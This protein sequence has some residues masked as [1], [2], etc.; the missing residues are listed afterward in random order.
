MLQGL[1][2]EAAIQ[3]TEGVVAAVPVL[4]DELVK[5]IY[6]SDSYQALLDIDNIDTGEQVLAAIL[7]DNPIGRVLLSGDKRFVQAFRVSLPGKWNDL[8]GS[9]ISFEACLLAIEEMYGFEYL[10]AR[11][12]EVRY[13][14]GSLRLALGINPNCEAFREALVSFDPCRGII[15]AGE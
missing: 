11:V 6:S 3:R 13:C 4:S 10:V 15:A 7:M 1:D 12:Y 9:I 14:D 2:P 5:D 8:N